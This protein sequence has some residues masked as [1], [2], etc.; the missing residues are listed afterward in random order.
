MCVKT[1]IRIC[2][3]IY[4]LYIYIVYYIYYIYMCVCIVLESKVLLQ[5]CGCL[6]VH[7]L[8]RAKLG[9]FR[10]LTTQLA[11]RC[12][13]HRTGRFVRHRRCPHLGAVGVDQ[14]FDPVSLGHTSSPIDG[15]QSQMSVGSVYGSV[16]DKHNRSSYYSNPSLGPLAVQNI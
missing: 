2:K 3:K 11:Q 14:G 13:T 4:I 7:L 8:F 1:N 12:P 6:F 16:Y 10:S 5:G 15:R 9:P